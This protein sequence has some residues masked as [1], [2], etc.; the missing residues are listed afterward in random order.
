MPT[1]DRNHLQVVQGTGT[2]G[3][4]VGIA[5]KEL[6]PDIAASKKAKKAAELFNATA[7]SRV[8]VA[9]VGDSW[10]VRSAHAKWIE[11]DFPMIAQVTKVA[12][13]CKGVQQHSWVFIEPYLE[14]NYTKYNTNGPFES[15]IASLVTAF[16][17][18]TFENS[19]HR[20][21]ICDLQ[22]SFINVSLHINMC[23][24]HNNKY[25]V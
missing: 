7:L 4:T 10:R 15:N 11:F 25:V 14:G 2:A 6:L 9:R 1:S 23:S 5:N 20:F 18:W 8:R 24:L 19:G 3:M 22:V 16:T 17:H 21:V 13:N 12:P